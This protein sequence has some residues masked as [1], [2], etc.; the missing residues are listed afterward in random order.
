[1]MSKA[2]SKFSPEAYGRTCAVRTVTATGS[3]DVFPFLVQGSCLSAATLH[4]E[5]HDH[6][7][8]VRP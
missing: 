5:P 2:I 1:M 6:D 7:P 3:E 4:K 8:P